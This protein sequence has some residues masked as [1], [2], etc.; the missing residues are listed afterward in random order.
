MVLLRGDEEVAS[1]ALL[2]TTGRP[3]LGLVDEV[4]RLQLA[5]KRLGC[6]I[7][8]RHVCPDLRQLLELVGLHDVAGRPPLEVVGK[9]EGG[10]ET[11]VEEVV[12][13]DD[14]VA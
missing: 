1:W 2:C 4:A 14:P 8:L 13:P 6:S 3:D 7:W 11:G 10:E 5:A 9:A 12:V